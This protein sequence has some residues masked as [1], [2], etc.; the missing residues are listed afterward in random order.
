MHFFIFLIQPWMSISF[1]YYHITLNGI[2]F[3]HTDTNAHKRVTN[4]THART[5][6]H[7]HRYLTFTISF[8]ISPTLKHKRTTISRPLHTHAH[9]RTNAHART[10]VI[11]TQRVSLQSA[12]WGD[13]TAYLQPVGSR[14]LQLR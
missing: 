8:I 7:L 12:L 1:I 14:L 2:T 9:A 13:C 5:Y 11:G 3:T 10:H 4:T 6:A